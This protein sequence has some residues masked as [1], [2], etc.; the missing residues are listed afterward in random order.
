MIRHQRPSNAGYLPSL[1]IEPHPLEELLAVPVVTKN[2]PFFDSAAIY[3]MACARKVDSGSPGHE[4]RQFN[5]YAT[6]ASRE[7]ST[8]L[9]RFGLPDPE[10]RK[11]VLR[12]VPVLGS[13]VG[14][15]GDCDPVV[16]D[17][18]AF[19]KKSNVRESP[20]GKPTRGSY[21]RSS[22]A[23]EMSA[24][25]S[26]TSPARRGSNRGATRRPARP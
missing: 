14:L 17:Q 10:H 6:P 1:E 23:R 2:I 20:S 11:K 26:R 19:R 7:K 18:P 12:N 13:I 8:K 3:M 9:G 24:R 21:P 4:R 5:I 16:P 15:S 22:F 25:E